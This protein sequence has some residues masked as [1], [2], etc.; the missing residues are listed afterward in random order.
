M[1]QFEQHSFPRKVMPYALRPM[2]PGDVAQVVEIERDAFPT[3]W[4]PTPFRRELG[5]RLARYIVACQRPPGLPMSGTTYAAKA[6]REKWGL[7]PGL[8]R[9]VRRL[10]GRSDS[11]GHDSQEPQDLVVGFA[12]LWF[13]VDE[14]HI[15]TIGVRSDLRRRGIGELLLIGAIGLALQR[16]SRVVTLEVRASNVAAQALYQKYGFQTVGRRRAY[17]ADNNE[18]ALIMTTDS[19]RASAFQ[20][21]LRQLVS[22]HRARWGHADGLWPHLG[23]APSLTTTA[24]TDSCANS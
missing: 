18:D 11:Q 5:N 16:G 19:I 13:M 22:A 4:P 6:I 17:Y 8:V 10:W 2:R 3:M 7:L 23:L 21:R 12:G 24:I 14:A 15:T 1:D 20:E 9:G